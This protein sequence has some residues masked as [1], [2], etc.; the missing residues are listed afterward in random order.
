LPDFTGIQGLAYFAELPR[1]WVILALCG[2]V[3]AV[4][5]YC[6]AQGA[7]LLPLSALGFTQFISPTLQFILGLFV[8][9]EAFPP[10]YFAAFAFIWTAVILYIVSLGLAPK[11]R[12]FTFRR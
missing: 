8:F 9:R 2:L 10:H 4:P 12:K 11:K 6:F 3:T 1:T 5:L 7:K